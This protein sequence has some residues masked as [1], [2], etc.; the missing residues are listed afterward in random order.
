MT[1]SANTAYLA[2]FL[3]GLTLVFP[4]H[5]SAQQKV[6]PSQEEALKQLQGSWVCIAEE[7]GGKALT[8]DEIKVK[9]RR[10]TIA[11]NKFNM[12]RVNNNSLGKW[13]GRI[14]VKPAK[15]F[16]EFNFYGKGHDGKYIERIGIY[17]LQ[18]D[19]FRLCYGSPSH[20]TH[21]ERPTKFETEAGAG[22]ELF[23]FKRDKE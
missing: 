10:V 23:V 6:L 13:D 11:E 2:A 20:K 7:V 3:L 12:S 21:P 8:K 5:G 18:G 4:N 1:T 19:T 22:R 17:E 16:N 9:N 15:P 14:E